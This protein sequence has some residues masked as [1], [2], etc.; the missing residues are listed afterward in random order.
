MRGQASEVRWLEAKATSYDVPAF[1]LV[2]VTGATWEDPG[3]TVLTIEQPSADHVYPLAICSHKPIVAG[4]Y[5]LV[6]LDGPAFVKY[7][8]AATPSA[9][10]SWGAASGS[11]LATKDTNGLL[12]IGSVDATK[13]VVF[14]DICRW[15]GYREIITFRLA[16]AL[17]ISDENKT[18][19]ISEQVGQGRPSPYTGAGEIT[20]HNMPS[21]ATGNYE[22]F[23]DSGDYGRAAWMYGSHYK[24]L[25]LECA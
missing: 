23:A 5:G 12:I 11:F 20:V 25:I 9:G 22:F 6:T 4:D 13:E 15:N 8:T 19:T 3:R 17:T 10:Q 1:G 14:A 21:V 7:N 16:A 18:A 2:M 24:I